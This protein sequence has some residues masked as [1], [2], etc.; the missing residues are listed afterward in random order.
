[1]N[2]IPFDPYDFFG[3]LAA[4]LVFVVGMELTLGFPRVLGQDLKVVDIAALTVGVYVAGQIV[5]WAAKSLLEDFFVDKI[6]ARPSTNLLKSK[7]PAV[8][9]FLF[10]GFYK[11]LPGAIRNKVLAKAKSE[12]V[13]DTGEALF[14]HVR[15]LPAIRDDDALIRKLDSF[16]NQYGFNRNLAFTSLIVGL[17]FVVKAKVAVNT[18]VLEYGITALVVSAVLL[19]RYLKFFRQY[20]YEMLNVYA[21]KL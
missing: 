2:R 10:P 6:L 14:Q 21:G 15:F 20:S 5:A 16:R 12:G 19:Y 1:M 7:K 11:P 4:G 17:A 8:R 9:G 18:D 13:E 3:Y